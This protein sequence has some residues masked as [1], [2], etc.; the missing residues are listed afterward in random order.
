[1]YAFLARR[2]YY[3]LPCNATACEIILTVERCIIARMDLNLI[4][5]LRVKFS[6]CI[7]F[8][9]AGGKT[10]ALFHLAR[11]LIHEKVVTRVIVTATSHL[12]VW[13]IPL[14]DMHI[15]TESTS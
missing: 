15:V 6:S 13:Q 8:V 12:G 2:S 5:A 4:Q 10:T 9:G 7:A 14:A 3:T 1:M 11:A